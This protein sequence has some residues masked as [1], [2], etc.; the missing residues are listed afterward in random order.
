MLP[1]LWKVGIVV[2]SFRIITRRVFSLGRSVCFYA[3]L[4]LPH[5]CCGSGDLA[6]YL[7]LEH[8]WDRDSHGDADQHHA[9]QYLNNRYS[10]NIDC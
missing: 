4:Q 2:V 6:A 5:L 3:N 7:G 1:C 10:A 8:V 9:N